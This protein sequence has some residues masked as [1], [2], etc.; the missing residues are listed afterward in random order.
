MRLD[1]KTRDG[2][3]RFV[4]AKRLGEVVTAP[5]D[6]AAVREVLDVIAPVGSAG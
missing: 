2:E 6:E 5:I 1:K 4:L 3:F